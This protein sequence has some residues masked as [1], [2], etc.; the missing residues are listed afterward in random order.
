MY[1][2][3]NLCE[4]LDLSVHC[5]PAYKTTS[6]VMTSISDANSCHCVKLGLGFRHTVDCNTYWDRRPTCQQI[7]MVYAQIISILIMVMINPLTAGVAYIWVFI[8]Y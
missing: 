7:P 8:Y 6:F 5:L 1:T 3:N 2:Q 4:I